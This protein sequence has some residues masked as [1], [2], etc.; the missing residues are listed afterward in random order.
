VLVKQRL[1]INAI[2]SVVSV[3]LM[4]VVVFL[5]IYRVN[6]AFEASKIADA[7][8]T[9]SFE[10]LMIRTDYHR[11][12]SERSKEQL[13][14]KHGQIGDLLKAA[15][16][17]F[18]DPEDKKTISELLTIHESIGKFSKTIRENRE[19]RRPH[20]RPDSLSQE[21]EDRLLNQL[22]MRVYQTVLLAS[23]LQE[24]GNEAVISSLRLAGGGILFVILLVGFATLINSWTMGR[25]ITDRIRQLRQGA[26]VIGDGNLDHRIDVSGDD[27]LAGLA[28]SFN[29]MTANLRGSYNDLEKEI[30]MRR[31]AEDSLNRLNFELS[32]RVEEQTAEVRRANESLE[33][34][35]VE[36]T[37]ELEAANDTLRASRVAAL[38]LMEDAL[39][40]RAAV[41]NLMEDAEA[42]RQLA[43]KASDELQREASARK[44]REEQL[45]IFIEYAPASL[46]MFD[47]EMRYLSVSRRWLS[48]YKLPQRD[49]RGLSHYEVFPDIPESWREIHRRALAGEIVQSDN[50]RF[51]RADGSAQWLR[52]EVR[53]WYNA[54][55]HV[56]GI[57]VFSEDIT[58]RIQA[59]EV[60]NRSNAELSHLN[61]EL[62]SFIYSVSHDLRAPLRA[63]S[64]FASIISASSRDRL[65]EKEK[66]YMVRILDGTARMSQLIDD[67]LDLS[68]ISQSE[69]DR[70]KIDLSNMILTIIARLREAE[71]G[72]HAE[73]NIQT[74]VIAQAD[75]R[76]MEVALSNLLGNAWKFT[77]KTETPVIEFGTTEQE[78]K[79]VYFIRDNGAGFDPT[80]KEKMFLPFHRLHTRDQFEGTG[81]GLA[82]VERIIHRHGGKIWADGEPGKG[83]TIYFTLA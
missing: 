43:E 24:S 30:E 3:L 68:R 58:E 25:S 19:K 50:D 17:T 36:R 34:R 28:A 38:N 54:A 49:L 15:S 73:I 37:A 70:K 18:P 65:N 32:Q 60:I 53:P 81:I 40:A 67:L 56:A 83:A 79:T 7:I 16:E 52:W 62:E 72:R 42:A 6:R 29:E 80:Y 23:K 77:S 74:G 39:A 46:A 82:I 9:T 61:R 66:N 31:Q 44:E 4:I 63:I 26:L 20:V 12:G 51:D 5:T 45:R 10:R 21:L 27:E 78:G 64:G 1:R 71:A 48:D 8:I 47:L 2:V 75:P 13:L 76:V 35:I 55:G 33:Q 22:N 41:L 69:I 14:A 57:V 11:T 59:E